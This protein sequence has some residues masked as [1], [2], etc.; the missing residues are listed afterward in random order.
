[1]ARRKIRL[2]AT[3]LP[4]G[5]KLER[6]AAKPNTVGTAKHPWFKDR[7]KLRFTRRHPTG[8][9]YSKMKPS[10]MHPKKVKKKMKK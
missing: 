7:G 4:P 6:S 2:K 5:I 3:H 1:M 9:V 10:S 8:A